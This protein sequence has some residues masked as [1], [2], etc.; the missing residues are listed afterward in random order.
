MRSGMSWIKW[1]FL[2]SCFINVIY[3]LLTLTASPS[4]KANILAS[5][6]IFLLIIPQVIYIL[7]SKFNTLAWN[8]TLI[9]T[10]LIVVE[11]IFFLKI[12]E[13]PSIQT[14]TR[15]DNQQK[16]KIDFLDRSPYIKFKPNVN[17]RSMGFR[18]YDFVSLWTTDQFGY[19]NVA[20]KNSPS[21]YD[22]IALGDSFTEGMGVSIKD[23]WT[24]QINQSGRL[25][26]YNAG[27]QGYSA[28]QMYG[29]Y[30]LLNAKINHNGV[31]IG[32]LPMIYNREQWFVDSKLDA[33]QKGY[34]GI[35]SILRGEDERANT[36]MA[37]FLRSIYKSVAS[38]LNGIN[39][40]YS[41]EIP[42]E[43]DTTYSLSS[44]SNWIRYVNSITLIAEK[45][46]SKNKRVLLIQFPKRHEIYFS[47]QEQGLNEF[48]ETQ[49]YIELEY[50]K[51]FIPDYVEV[52]DM[53][54]FFKNDFRTSN[55]PL[56][57]KKDG[58]MNEHG[59]KL[60][61]K[62]IIDYLNGCPAICN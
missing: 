51:R 49:Y 6:I 57:F 55:K 16:S 14:W 31:I 38:S 39:K 20:V 1:M 19:K 41:S 33:M 12:V 18:G 34:G 47:A 25:S 54:P 7:R 52:L 36:F 11:G 62:F 15:I 22:F 44:N 35:A 30:E 56:Y 45:A 21:H 5:A 61:A 24:N 48:S 32:A 42:L 46:Y 29:T 60:V 37:S 13:N 28:S 53:F 9:A 10:S 58:H 23:T 50:L 27:V 2:I 43:V 3:L 4:A 40:H 26:I 17:V 8:A 59:N